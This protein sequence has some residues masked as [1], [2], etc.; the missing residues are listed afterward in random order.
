MPVNS[1]DQPVPTAAAAAPVAAASSRW[2]AIFAPVLLATLAIDQASKY[3]LFALPDS[4][5]LP[6]WL[7][8]AVNPGV[9][10]GVFGGSPNA[11]VAMTL[12]LIP[13]LT[14][15]WWRH[16]RRGVAENT[17]FGL[18]LGGALGNGWDRVTAASRPAWHGARGVRDFILVDLNAVGID[19]RWPN[20]NLA[21]AAICVGFI[22]LVL[23][24]WRKP[25]GEAARA[26]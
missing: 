1:L 11:V 13:L 25:A 6:S 17:A 26:C 16:F 9:A 7:E 3:Y 18:I 8:R 15:V 2:A 4:A 23:L 10:W 24:A 20:F 19:Y 22:L 14:W 5:E 12:A 21:D